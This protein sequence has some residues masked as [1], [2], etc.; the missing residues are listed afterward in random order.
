MR[1][2]ATVLLW[3]L[4]T[5]ALLVAVP[6]TWA[7]HNVVDESG[8]VALAQRAATER[9]VQDAVA[10]ELGNQLGTL[11]GSS[12][13]GDSTT[14]LRGAAS[15]YTRSAAFP[16]QFATANRIVHR[17]MFTESVQQSD[18]S[19]RW[20]IDLSPML[21]DSSFQ[22]SLQGFGIDAQALPPLE[23]PLTENAPDSLRPGQLRQ[24]TKWGPWVS[25]GATVLTGAFG[26]LTVA[27][28]KRRGKALVA[29]AV[30]AL[31]VG[32]AG[33]VAIEV[34][35]GRINDALNATSGNVRQV[36]DAMVG[37]AIGSLHLW[38]NL[39]L[40]AGGALVVLGFLVSLMG[41]ARGR[42]GRSLTVP[43]TGAPDARRTR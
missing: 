12:G 11:A 43:T 7:Q 24:M 26:L 3:L 8:Y 21:A 35:R 30:S 37:E 41:A 18:E 23:V 13:F 40:L 27:A 36:A 19:G 9:P 34:L 16:G 15:I 42:M 38:L 22:Q 2:V 20:E 1:F 6:T 39:T 5:A 28:A 4:T 17:W 10:S 25:V 31:L 14:L 33:W 29:L 32:A